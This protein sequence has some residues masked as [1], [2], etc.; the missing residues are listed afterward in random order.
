MVYSFLGSPSNLASQSW[1]QCQSFPMI[2]PCPDFYG[3]LLAEI[4]GIY[5]ARLCG[6]VLPSLGKAC[7]C[8]SPDCG[9]YPIFLFPYTIIN[10]L[11]SIPPLCFFVHCIYATLSLI[12]KRRSLS[13]SY[14][15]GYSARVAHGDLERLLGW[16]RDCLTTT[17]KDIGVWRVERA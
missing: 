7:C 16:V 12:L 1:M 11:F 8:F 3:S 13:I 9:V 15:R 6:S 4:R 10:L 5:Q 14:H 17:M 2:E